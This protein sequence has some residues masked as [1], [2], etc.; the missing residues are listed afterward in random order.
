ML[1]NLQVIKLK[2]DVDVWV[3]YDFLKEI[4]P[5]EDLNLINVNTTNIVLYDPTNDNCFVSRYLN[6][7]GVYLKSEMT[8]FRISDFRYQFDFF[9]NHKDSVDELRK[10][11]IKI[12]FDIKLKPLFR[13]EE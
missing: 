7:L 8:P 11:G 13:E 6:D 2:S 5:S 10:K 1:S 9:N 4:F 12:K 3:E